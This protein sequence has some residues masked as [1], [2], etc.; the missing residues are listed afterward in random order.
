MHFLTSNPKFQSLIFEDATMEN[1]KE[2]INISKLDL[3]VIIELLR[4]TSLSESESAIKYLK[5]LGNIQESRIL[6]G[7][8][9][10]NLFW[11]NLNVSKTGASSTGFKSDHQKNWND[12]WK[13]IKSSLIKILKHLRDREILKQSTFCK[14]MEEIRLFETWTKQEIIQNWNH[15]IEKQIR[16]LGFLCRKP[17]S[18]RRFEEAVITVYITDDK[19]EKRDC[20]RQWG[21]LSSV[22]SYLGSFFYPWK[23]QHNTT[24]KL[25]FKDI[26]LDSYFAAVLDLK[27]KKMV[28]T[29]LSK[30]AF[31]DVTIVEVS[32]GKRIYLKLHYI[33]FK[34]E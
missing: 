5:C 4:F 1:I 29:L 30:Q 6:L 24:D 20:K 23:N 25:S 31:V 7:M 32:K 27:M 12:L 18:T 22:F 3:L 14:H 33:L 28:T 13:D 8:E 34:W 17:A 11:E 21:F 10:T 15:P 9:N 19:N 26:S 2:E 16:Y